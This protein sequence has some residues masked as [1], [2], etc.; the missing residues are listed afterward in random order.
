MNKYLKLKNRNMPRKYKI[1]VFMKYD[2]K[3][4]KS[5]IKSIKKWYT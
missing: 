3:A 5:I 2:M 1:I 4:K